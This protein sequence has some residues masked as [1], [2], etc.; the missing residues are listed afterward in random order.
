MRL[1]FDY[2]QINI[3]EKYIEF[4]IYFLKKFDDGSHYLEDL[5]YQDV[6]N[7]KLNFKS[8]QKIFKFIFNIYIFFS[9]EISK[10]KY[11]SL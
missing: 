1:V 8:F 2:M 4:L 11:K 5:R 9:P 3:K 10:I 7:N 6:I